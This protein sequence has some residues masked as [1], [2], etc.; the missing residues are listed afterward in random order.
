MEAILFLWLIFAEHIE[1]QRTP[2]DNASSEARCEYKI[3]NRSG[4]NYYTW[5]DFNCSTDDDAGQQIRSYFKTVKGDFSLE[6]LLF[7][8]VSFPDG[9][10]SQI[11]K[12]FLKKIA[13]GESFSYFAETKEIDGSALEKHIFMLKESVLRQMIGD[14]PNET[15]I[16]YKDDSILVN[17][18]YRSGDNV[19]H[20]KEDIEKKRNVDYP[21]LFI[22]GGFVGVYDACIVPIEYDNQTYYI[23][24]ESSSLHLLW[25]NIDPSIT[26][27]EFS[28]KMRKHVAKD[29]ALPVS[30]EVFR[31][32]QSC[33]VEIDAEMYDEYK[34]LPYDVFFDKYKASLY[35]MCRFEQSRFKFFAFLCWRNAIHITSDDESGAMFLQV[36]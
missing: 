26:R 15:L 16:L 6:R 28:D 13:P 20:H 24:H 25:K 3:E 7:D 32:V 17:Y 2:L 36:Y 19:I 22:Y 21:P 35:S 4:D 14:L 10:S 11:G 12:T 27:E 34:E 33:I 29:I 8:N 18:P 31:E 9:F 30:A 5:V 23:C 1:L